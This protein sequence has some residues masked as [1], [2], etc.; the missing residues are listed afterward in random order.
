MRQAPWAPAAGEDAA[1]FDPQQQSTNSW[2][3]FTVLLTSV[4]AAIY[5]VGDALLRACMHAR[6]HACSPCMDGAA[7]SGHMCV[8]LAPTPLRQ[9]WIQPGV[10]LADDYLQLLEGFSNNNPEAT[11][12]LILFVFALFHSGLAG[13]RPEGAEAGGT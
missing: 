4:L 13:L 11:I 6:R 10:G 9:V 7:C 1:F 8:P 5:V 3:L 2:V 12:L